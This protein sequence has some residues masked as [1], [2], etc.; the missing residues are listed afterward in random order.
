MQLLRKLPIYFG[1]INCRSKA[2]LAE[3]QLELANLREIP[4][5]AIDTLREASR[6]RLSVMDAL[7]M[8]AGLV[9]LNSNP[10]DATQSAKA[11]LAA[12][13]TIVAA[14][15]RLLSGEEPIAPLNE[16]ISCSEL[17]LYDGW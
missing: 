1:M 13:P 3:F 15:W 6:Q 7:R 4:S 8:V 9:S 2:E 12:I 14:Y 5:I 16:L 11:I 10:D 17:S